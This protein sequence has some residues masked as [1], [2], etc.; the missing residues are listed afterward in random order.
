M[1]LSAIIIVTLG[2]LLFFGGA[3][4]LQIHSRK[5]NRPARCGERQQQPAAKTTSAG[6]RVSRRVARSE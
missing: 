4:W 3:A 5:S 6:R 1:D 2:I